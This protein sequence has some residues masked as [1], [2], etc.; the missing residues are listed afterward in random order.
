MASADCIDVELLAQAHVRHHVLHRHRS[1]RARIELV[2]VDTAENEALAVEHE[3]RVEDFEAAEAHA[4]SHGLAIV[5]IGVVNR[6]AQR[7]QSRILRRPRVCA[8][9]FTPKRDAGS[10]CG[11]VFTP[12]NSAARIGE[13]GAC[14]TVGLGSL[15]VDRDIEYSH[16]RVRVVV[17]VGCQVSDVAGRQSYQ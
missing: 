16:A 4:L 10:V 1:A 12:H 5:S 6:E 2:A 7:I 17:S 13:L 8:V 15:K 3:D 9:Y 14:G 11:H